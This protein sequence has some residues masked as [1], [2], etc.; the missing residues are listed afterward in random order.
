MQLVRLVIHVGL[1]IHQYLAIV[2]FRL[3]MRDNRQR[4][5]V[6][7]GA[8]VTCSFSLGHRRACCVPVCDRTWQK[9]LWIQLA[10]VK[11]Y[12]YVD[13]Q[14]VMLFHKLT[15]EG[16][17]SAE[18]SQ[19][20]WKLETF[21][22]NSVKWLDTG[23]LI[24]VRSGTFSTLPCGYKAMTIFSSLFCFFDESKECF[25]QRLT[26]QGVYCHTYLHLFCGRLGYD[27]VV[28]GLPRNLVSIPGRVKRIFF[29]YK[30]RR[31][32]HQESYSAGSGDQAA[33]TES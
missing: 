4:K 11:D 14:R 30:M 28:H 1:Y 21:Q 6:K 31:Q 32:T 24:T 2:I 5:A 20:F 26:C 17:S 19:T 7:H 33:E 22:H 10:V 23:S 18:E 12:H 29:S 13:L 25:L 15:T 8:I 27:T 9:F 3:F 16:P